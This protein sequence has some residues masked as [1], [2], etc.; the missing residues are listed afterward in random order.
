[1]IIYN[2]GEISDY[3]RDVM[4]IIMDPILGDSFG[5]KYEMLLPYGKADGFISPAQV[6]S[7]RRQKRLIPALEEV[8][9]ASLCRELKNREGVSTE[10][11]WPHEQRTITVDGPGTLLYVTD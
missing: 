4:P 5:V 7:I 8:W 1:M 11:V 3:D 6:R 9:T 10:E 2:L